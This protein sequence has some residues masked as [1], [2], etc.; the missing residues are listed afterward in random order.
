MVQARRLELNSPEPVEIL[1]R[2][3]DPPKI[4]ASKGE[5]MGSLS[6]GW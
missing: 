4:P 5:K 1:D 6:A 3:V 2:H